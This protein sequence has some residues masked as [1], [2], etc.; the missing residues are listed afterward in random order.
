TQAVGDSLQGS[1]V[2][3]VAL[4]VRHLR[5]EGRSLPALGEGLGQGDREQG[6]DDCEEVPPDRPVDHVGDK[7]SRQREVDEGGNK[8]P[9]ETRT[10]GMSDWLTGKEGDPDEID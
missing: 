9:T 2:A 3:D 10:N 1:A 7:H 4:I 5:L 6:H 8:G